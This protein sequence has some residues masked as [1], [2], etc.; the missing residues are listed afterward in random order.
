MHFYQTV[1]SVF[2]AYYSKNWKFF[3]L[4]FTRTKLHAKHFLKTKKTKNLKLSENSK[5]LF[6]VIYCS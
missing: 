6:E 5:I 4:I 3:F 1:V 2:Y